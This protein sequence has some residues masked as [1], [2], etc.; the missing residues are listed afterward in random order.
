M[1]ALRTA[2]VVLTVTGACFIAAPDVPQ[3]CAKPFDC[4]ATGLYRCVSSR[5]L[6]QVD[7]G[8]AEPDCVCEINFPPRT[9]KPSGSEDAGPS[10]EWCTDVRPVIQRTC[11]ANCHGVDASYPKTPV[12][13]RLD[14]FEPPTARGLPGVHAKA[15]D[16]R[17][18]LVEYRMPPANFSEQPTSTER[19]VVSR[20]VKSGA[21]LGDGGCEHGDGG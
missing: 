15:G 20:W 2:W 19:F 14:Y 17:S 12:D 11:L 10:P 16:V 7:C 13:F 3:A 9:G 5:S 1:R 21:P 4:P 6:T 8:L 18:A